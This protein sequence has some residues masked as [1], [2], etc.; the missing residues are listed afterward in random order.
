MLN[1][2]E[3]KHDSWTD[4]LGIDF[5]SIFSTNSNVIE[6]FIAIFIIRVAD[7]TGESQFSLSWIQKLILNQSFISRLGLALDDLTRTKSG[8][9][10]GDTVT[11]L[12]VCELDVEIPLAFGLDYQFCRQFI[13]QILLVLE[14]FIDEFFIV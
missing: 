13:C 10:G 6:V 14:L 2:W 4:Q 8:L 11:K 7:N 12:S 3:I 1:F 5:S 9:N